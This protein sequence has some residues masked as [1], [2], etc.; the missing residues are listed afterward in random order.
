MVTRANPYYQ[1]QNPALGQAFAGIAEAMFP[2]MNKTQAEVL[3]K[4]AQAEASQ[5]QAAASYALAAERGQTTRGKSIKNDRY[6]A[7][8]TDLAALF[9][10]GGIPKDEP[11][12]SNPL[13]QPPAPIDYGAL[14]RGEP[15]PQ[16]TQPM[17]LGGR[18]ATD[19]LAAALQQMEAYGFKP[20]DIMKAIG[21]QQYLGTA[22]G[23]DPQ[24]ALP[25][26]P[27]AGVTSP[28]AGTAL[29]PTAQNRIS[30]RDAAEAK[31][32]ATA[33]EGMRSQNRLEIEGIREDGRNSRDANKATKGTGTK[34]P[35]LPV[36]TPSTSKAMRESLSNRLGQM[37]YKTVAPEAVDELLALASRQFQDPNSDAFK[38][39]A[40]AVQ[41]TVELLET[42]QVPG[43]AET[44]SRS[45]FGS[46]R[47]N[48][49]RV[50]P[51]ERGAAP[52][53]PAAA[54]PGT[55]KPDIAKIPG[56]PQ[57]SRLGT[58]TAQGWEVF[59]KS[60]KLIGHIKE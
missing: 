27:F 17:F 40:L 57:G 9:L 51:G 26:A 3:A 46:E 39:T 1:Y 42:G 32:Q 59:D 38:N 58:S 52:A 7:M 4:Q 2:G 54:K 10:S 33:V 16:D 5:G 20:Q 13:Y 36:V 44:L 15:I 8:P 55:T 25:F 12:T 56:I 24:A 23:P 29:S 50:P 53:A 41:N 30:A 43:V 47:R 35:T 48:L 28:N 19:Q 45:F 6:E 49:N 60:G 22:A 14:M 11:M 31:D 34:A 18:S 21:M 37:G